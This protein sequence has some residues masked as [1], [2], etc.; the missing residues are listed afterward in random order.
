[1]VDTGMSLRTPGKESDAHLK[2]VFGTVDVAS[3]SDTEV[4]GKM[5]KA[6]FAKHPG[7]SYVVLGGVLDNE[8]DAFFVVCKW[9]IDDGSGPLIVE[10]TP[11][12]D[13][14]GVTATKELLD[15]AADFANGI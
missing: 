1:S 6:A 2:E 13:D 8:S 4:V 12:G 14:K 10:V 5:F 3:L 9:R 7:L 11:T 15:I